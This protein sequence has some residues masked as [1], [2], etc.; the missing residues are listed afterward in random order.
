MLE[1]WTLPSTCFTPGDPSIATKRQRINRVSLPFYRW[2]LTARIPIRGY[3]ST[4]D[5]IGQHLLKRR[6]DLGFQQKEAARRLGVH[7]GGLENWEYGRTSPADRFMP[8][9]IR[10][11]G[12]IRQ[13]FRRR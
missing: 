13:P 9:V 5:H 10:F 1:H 2:S 3:P 7:P 8:A 6:L 4:L 12:T 11:W